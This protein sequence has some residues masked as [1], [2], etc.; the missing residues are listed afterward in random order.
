MFFLVSMP[1]KMKMI[2][3]AFAMQEFVVPLVKGMQELIARLEEQERK[4][5]EAGTK[6]LNSIGR[7]RLGSEE[8]K[9]KK[10]LDIERSCCSVPK[11][12]QSI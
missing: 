7:I 2:R 4:I 6:K 8:M 12:S 11:Q 10:A 9:L 1:L 3:T 5:A